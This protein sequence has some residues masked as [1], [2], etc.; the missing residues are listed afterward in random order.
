MAAAGLRKG[1]RLCS[2]DDAGSADVTSLRHTTICP[3]RECLN[4]SVAYASSFICKVR[5]C[6][7]MMATIQTSPVHG[8]R[9]QETLDAL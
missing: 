5:P 2:G 7:C 8:S 3:K 4:C 9:F 1:R 6:A